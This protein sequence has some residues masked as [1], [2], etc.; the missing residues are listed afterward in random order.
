MEIWGFDWIIYG[1]LVLLVAGLFATAVRIFREYERGVVFTLGRFTRVKGPGLVILVPIVQ[2]IVRVDLRTHVE[3]VPSQDV[4]SRDNVSVK[5]NAVLYYRDH[6]PGAGDHQGRELHARDQPARPDD[7]ALG[8]RQARARRD[9]GRARQAERR[10][11]G[12]S[13]PADRRLGD[14]GRQCRDQARRPQREHDPRHRQAGRGRA[15]APGAGDQRRR[16]AAGG[17]RSWSR[18]PRCSPG[19]RARCS[20]AISPR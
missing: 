2:Q 13:R 3:D 8:A 12:D 15:P 18:R 5:V 11:P 4:I 19:S 9:A 6:R 16:R 7:A 20:S 1:V 10:P 14:Q 17:R